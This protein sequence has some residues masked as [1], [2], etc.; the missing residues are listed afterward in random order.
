MK[1]LFGAIEAEKVKEFVLQHKLGCWE[2]RVGDFSVVT[3][4][5]TSSL[6][7]NLTYK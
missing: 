5:M 3:V 7:E 1:N 6:W 2:S 4:A